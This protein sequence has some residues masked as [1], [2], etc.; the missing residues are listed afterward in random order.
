MFPWYTPFAYAMP[1]N[2]PELF[3]ENA[4]V[5]FAALPAT[6]MSAPWAGSQALAEHPLE[7]VLPVPGPQIELV[8]LSDT[9]PLT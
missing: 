4:G 8:L 9:V 7:A 5:T 3:I 2:M 6:I 1:S